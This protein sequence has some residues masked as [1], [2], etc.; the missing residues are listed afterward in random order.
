[1]APERK[2][3]DWI[4]KAA[5]WALMFA[6]SLL[7]LLN[8]NEYPLVRR[9][10]AVVIAALALISAGLSL[11]ERLAPRR[12]FVFTGVLV[13]LG[14]DLNTGAATLPVI[15]GCAA[16]AAAWFYN[17]NVVKLASTAF[18]TVMLFQLGIAGAGVWSA[19]PPA[20]AAPAPSSG[21]ASLPPIV[22]LLMDSYLGT[23]GMGAD[24]AFAQLREQT[25]AFYLEHG[26][27]LYDGAYS[28]HANTANSV[29]YILSFGNAAPATV[30]QRSE[31]FSP[32]R[33]DYFDRLAARGYGI[34]ILG[35]DFINLCDG[36]PV[37][38]CRQFQHSKLSAITQ[39]S[40]STRDRATTI[41]VT[42]ASMSG[43]TSQI[44]NYSALANYLLG[45]DRPMMMR[46]SKKL[47]SPR[48]VVA[49]H[50]LGQVLKQ[51]E[52]GRA[53]F[54]HLLIPHEPY[55]FDESCAMKPRAQWN[56]EM[57]SAKIEARYA[58]Y[59]AQTVCMHRLLGE[60]LDVLQE[61]EAGR[62]AI[63]IIH[64]DH[65]SRIAVRRPDTLNPSPDLRDF[66]MTYS[67]LFAIR[68]P[69][70]EPELVD[71]RASLDELLEDFAES[72]FRTAPATGRQPAQ[73]ILATGDWVPKTRTNLPEY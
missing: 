54:A 50:D 21:D 58:N 8:F 30:S 61:T 66:A 35:A 22:H 4:A 41:G 55:V 26:F 6:A 32:G 36:Q 5:A 70:L 59:R 49:M 40:M 63:V 3:H 56:T 12:A 71:G 33:L 37:D 28:R 24:P 34:S 73:V 72:D 42:L 31:R 65:G 17:K 53:Y 1:M 29:P 68:A 25:I 7:N 47:A 52:Y 20:H 45:G 39:F 57:Q 18:G 2:R 62:Q 11:V 16:G 51:P 14:A 9:E 23:E 60:M 44:Y 67:T 64:G 15:L 46:N 48:A 27:R 19:S 10:V 38:D 43:L 69:G 13:G